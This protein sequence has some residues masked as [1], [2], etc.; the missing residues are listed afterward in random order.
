[1][2]YY[3]QAIYLTVIHVKTLKLV[4]GKLVL[5]EIYG[6]HYGNYRASTWD[7]LNIKK[8]SHQYRDPHVKDKTVSRPSYL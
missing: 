1:M 6:E 2:F 8:S 5:K 4:R 3:I 7:R